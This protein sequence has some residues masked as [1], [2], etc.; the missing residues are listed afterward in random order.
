ML[1]DWLSGRFVF[2]KVMVLIKL[3]YCESCGVLFKK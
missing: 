1:V 2:L 3:I